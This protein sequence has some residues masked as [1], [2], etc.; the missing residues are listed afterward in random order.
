MISLKRSITDF[1]R[2]QD[3]ST[4]TQDLLLFALE[5]VKQ[6][7]VETD[8]VTTSEFR[9][10]F[11]RVIKKIRGSDPIDG[12]VLKTE[13]R[14]ELRDY[15]ERGARYIDHLRTE[16]TSTS[17][18]L[19]ELLTTCQSDSGA[20][21]KLNE[22]VVRVRSL[23]TARSMEDVRQTARG[24]A[25]A[26]AQCA[27]QMKLERD[28][29]VVQ[30]RDEIRTLQ[31]AVEDAQRAARVDDVTGCY[32]RQEVERLI[33][34]EMV[35][36]RLTTVV[37]IW[38]RNF[39]LLHDLYSVRII[40][41]L[42]ISFAKRLAGIAKESA[43]GRWCGD[44]FCVVTPRQGSRDLGAE[45]LRRCSGAYVVVHEGSDR[46]VKLQLVVT[47]LDPQ[48]DEDVDGFL[49]KVELFNARQRE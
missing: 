9:E 27:E 1:E 37:H 24:I 35:A 7:A 26:I 36:G 12:A 6:Y 45:I 25:T 38:L 33:R 34:R 5:S 13:I 41:Q 8:P 20:E 43:I 44:I 39:E 40:D 47:H 17:K 2:L 29:L 3:L 14:G 15:H 48:P 32:N 23:E 30:L 49:Q 46:S 21:K 19:S 28:G 31:K 4:E 22:Q 10:R 16:L 42:A 18:A 11:A